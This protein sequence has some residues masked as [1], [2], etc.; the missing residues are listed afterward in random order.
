MSCLLVRC[1]LGGGY[2]LGQARPGGGGG[3]KESRRKDGPNERTR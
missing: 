3:M 2:I 1:V